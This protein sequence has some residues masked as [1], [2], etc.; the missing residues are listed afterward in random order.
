MWCFRLLRSL[1]ARVRETSRDANASKA[2]PLLLLR[3]SGEQLWASEHTDEYV[4]RLREG[5][6]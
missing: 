6:E 2:D 5:W 1:M 4:C 3:G